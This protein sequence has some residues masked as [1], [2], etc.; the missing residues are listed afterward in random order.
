MA[1]L[2]FFLHAKTGSARSA[3]PD[4]GIAATQSRFRLSHT[5]SLVG[6]A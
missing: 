4:F 2:L 6:G 5:V 1:L 3:G